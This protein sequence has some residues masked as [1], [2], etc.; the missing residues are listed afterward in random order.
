[1]PDYAPEYVEALLHRTEYGTVERVVEALLEGT[2]PPPEAIQLRIASKP[3][4]PQ[5]RDAFDGEEMDISRFRMG[6]KRCDVCVSDPR[7]MKFTQCYL[8]SCLV[9]RQ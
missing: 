1:L 8:F 4:T 3:Q 2:A 6:K 7:T 9:S 5:P